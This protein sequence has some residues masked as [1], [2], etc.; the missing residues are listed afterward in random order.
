VTT[1]QRVANGARRLP[2]TAQ[3]AV[4]CIALLDADTTH[5]STRS[6]PRSPT[7]TASRPRRPP[8]FDHGHI[9]AGRRVVR[10]LRRPGATWLVLTAIGDDWHAQWELIAEAATLLD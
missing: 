10:G 3:T 2:D 7:A 1:P 5:G 6:S 4:G 8:T 9:D